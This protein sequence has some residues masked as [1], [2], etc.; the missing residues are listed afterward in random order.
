MEITGVLWPGTVFPDEAFRDLNSIQNY[1]DQPKAENFAQC[2]A[3]GHV[4]PKDTLRCWEEE[5]PRTG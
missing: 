4:H 3:G 1:D 5:K 2:R